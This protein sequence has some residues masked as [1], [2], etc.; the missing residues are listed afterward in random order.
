M[1]FK[2]Q[3]MEKEIEVGRKFSS[4]QFVRDYLEKPQAYKVA[5][6]EVKH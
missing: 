6:E 3:E 4:T 2:I 5:Y 1:I